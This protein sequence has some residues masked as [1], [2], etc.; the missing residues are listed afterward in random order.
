MFSKTP[1][2]SFVYDLIDVFMLLGTKE[3]QGLT[4]LLTQH[5]QEDI[6]VE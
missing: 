6:E 1:I 3:Y 4:F 5:W 2:Q